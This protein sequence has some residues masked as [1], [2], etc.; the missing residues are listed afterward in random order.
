MLCSSHVQIARHW[1]VIR[2]AVILMQIC[3]H[4]AR[5]L[6]AEPWTVHSQ[7]QWGLFMLL[8][9]MN[10]K[11][12]FSSPLLYF[13]LNY[14]NLVCCHVN[15]FNWKGFLVALFCT[16][17]SVRVKQ[18]FK[19][20]ANP[21]AKEGCQVFLSSVEPSSCLF[22]ARSYWASPGSQREIKPAKLISLCLGQRPLVRLG[23][24][25]PPPQCHSEQHTSGLT[26][27][28]STSTSVL[29][30]K[31]YTFMYKGFSVS[32]QQNFEGHG[33]A[34]MLKASQEIV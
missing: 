25:I 34:W 7:P 14:C 30:K 19:T 10:F 31:T 11:A 28:T 22:N 2:H 32:P 29:S 16:H 27:T 18:K 4:A 5:Q 12:L 3:S 6:A 20:T 17:P 21:V 26:G 1:T 9:L 23:A 13:S 33:K 24:Q 15:H 8:P